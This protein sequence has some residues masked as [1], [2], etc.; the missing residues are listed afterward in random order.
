MSLKRLLV[1][2]M[3]VTAV[4][5]QAPGTGALVP[6]QHVIAGFQYL[7]SGTLGAGTAPADPGAS[8]GLAALGLGYPILAGETI[9]FTNVDGILPHTVTSCA[10]P[11][12]GVPAPSGLFGSPELGLGGSYTTPGLPAGTYMYFCLVHAFM[13]GSFTVI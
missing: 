4:L 8:A 10:A 13:R 6:H 5:V 3:I 1:C 12:S 9:T 11:C 2:S 7:P